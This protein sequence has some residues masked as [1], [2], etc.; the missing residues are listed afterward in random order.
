MDLLKDIE[1]ET[2]VTVK[3]IE[4]GT[5]IKEHLEHLGIAEGVKLTVL[6]TEPVHVHWGPISVKVADKEVIVAHGWADRIYV[7]KEGEI[8]PFL[9]LEEGDKG[10]VKTIEEGKEVEKLLAEFGVKEGAELTLL[11]HVPDRTIVFKIDDEEIKMGEGQASKVLVEH[12]GKTLQ[13]N[14][15]KEGT[16][17]KISKIIGGTRLKEKFEQMQKYLEEIPAKQREVFLLRN[18]EELSY[19][20]IAKITGKSVGALKANYHHAFKK[21]KELMQHYEK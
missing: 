16:K 20:E 14:Y 1:P 21:I 3:K 4:G 8:L 19:D 5:E 11:H 12:E 9:R 17:A 2:L 7:E 18:F 13:I 6:A 10:V 15:L